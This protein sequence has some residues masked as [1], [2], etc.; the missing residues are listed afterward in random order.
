MHAAGRQSTPTPPTAPTSLTATAVDARASSLDVDR[1]R[2]TTSRWPATGSSGARAPAARPSPRSPRRPATSF[3]D[4]GLLAVDQL[5]LPGGRGRPVRQR[6]RLLQRGLGDHAGRADRRSPCRPGCAVG[7]WPYAFDDGAGT[8]VADAVGQRQHRHDHRR[9]TW[10][11]RAS[12]AAALELQRRRAA[13]VRVPSSASLNLASAMTLAAWIQPSASAERLAH[14]HAARDRRLLPERQQQ[15]RPHCCRRGGGTFGG[16]IDTGSA[17]PTASPVG[18]WTHVALTYDGTTLRLYVNGVLASAGGADGAHPDASTSPLW[19]GGNSPYGEYFQGVIDEVRVYNRALI[20]DRDPD[21]HDTRRRSPPAPDTTAA[22]RAD[23]S[24]RDRRQRRRRST[25]R[26]RPRPTTSASPATASSAA[27]APGCSNFAAGRH[28]DRGRPSATPASRRHDQLQLPG[29]R[30][31]RRRQPQRLLQRRRRRRPRRRR[32]RLA[33]TAPDR[34]RRRPP[35][36]PPRSTWRGPL[37]RQRR[38]HRL[39]RRAVPGRR[40]HRLR[41]GAARRP[42]TTFSRHRPDAP[43]T[44]YSYRVSRR[45]RR[46]QPERLLDGRP[47]ATTAS[48]PPP[49][50]GLVAAY[51][52]DEGSGTTAA[53][54]SGNGNTGTIDRRRPGRRRASSATALSFNGS[55]SAGAGAVVGVAEPVVGDDAVGV[56]QPVGHRSPAG[57]RSCR[58]ETDAYFLNASNNAAAAC[59]PAVARS[60]AA[61][62]WSERSDGRTR[63][64]AWTHVALTYDGTTLRLYVNGVQARQPGADRAH[65]GHR[66][67]A[68]DRWQQPVRRVLPGFDRRRPGLQPG[69]HARP[70]SR[71]TWPR[72]SAR[73][74]RPTRPRRRPR[75]GLTATAVGTYP[76]QPDVDRGD[77]QRR[78]HR[79][80]GRA[81]HRAP[82]A[83]P[84]PRSARRP[85][86]ASPTPGSPPATSYSYRVRAG[87]RRRQP[88][89]LLERSPPPPRPRPTRRRRRHR[90]AWPRRRRARSQVEPD[91]DRVDRQRRRHRLPR[92]ALPGCRLLHLR[93]GRHAD[94]DDRSATPAWPP[95][96]RYSYR[97]LRRRRR[98]QPQRLLDT[99]PRPRRRRRRHDGADRADR[100]DRHRRRAPPRST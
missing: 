79:L 89:R 66:Q 9:A 87:R 5:Q 67:P 13:L 22:D 70:R 7:P 38:R 34:A 31:R 45:R 100:P 85:R 94:R 33:P 59:P 35:P 2:P 60:A 36:A 27:R 64:D 25:W 90:R 78:R 39:P 55:S 1:R 96:P 8:T 24:D 95:L 15:R 17:V 43:S 69:A 98:R 47:S 51:S 83:R 80:P 16:S 71:P 62:Q 46:R 10:T 75:P 41:P 82:A 21:R 3:A 6:E 44:S 88:Q 20:A 65:P 68:V 14:H 40:L 48:A 12:T 53:D 29:P 52:F 18:A 97:V 58:R 73:R 49:P 28:A 63:S 11:T 84:S 26:G 77:R 91:V 76:G 72:R 93:P 23:R 92:R 86:P 4:T 61:T 50:T 54:A 56:D 37:D 81:L 57:A 30:H 42:T 19:I 74:R 99:W 32:T